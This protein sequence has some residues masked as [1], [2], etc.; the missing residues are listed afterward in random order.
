MTTLN[1][2]SLQFNITATGLYALRAIDD[3]ADLSL[4]IELLCDDL[5]YN[6]YRDF[7][8]TEKNEIAGSTR[9]KAK[10][11]YSFNHKVYRLLNRMVRKGFSVGWLVEEALYYGYKKGMVKIH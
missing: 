9:R 3:P 5:K 7:L 10:A 11:S 8:C 4:L 2:V 6:N 1:H